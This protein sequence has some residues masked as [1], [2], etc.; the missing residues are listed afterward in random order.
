MKESILRRM[1]VEEVQPYIEEILVPIE[2][3]VEVRNGKKIISNR[4]LYP[5]YV[6][7][8]LAL[9]DENRRRIEK[10]WYFIKETAGVIGFVGGDDPS[11]TPDYEIQDIKDQITESEEH[12]KPRVQFEVGETIKSNDGPFLNCSGVVEEIDFEKGKLK[13][14]VN[15]F[16][17]NTPVDLEYWQVEKVQ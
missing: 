6:F 16:G 7:I 5:G 8:H 3:V 2:K 9:V 15:I 1:L 14:E 11:P 17:R 13:V 10:P 12:E 4:K